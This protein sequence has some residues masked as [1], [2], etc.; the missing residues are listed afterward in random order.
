MWFCVALGIQL[1][2]YCLIVLVAFWV[3]DWFCVNRCKLSGFFI[4]LLREL[5]NNFYED[6]VALVFV[7]RGLI[8]YYVALIACTNFVTL[9]LRSIAYDCCG[10]VTAC[11]HLVA[12]CDNWLLL[13]VLTCYMVVGTPAAIGLYRYFLH[14]IAICVATT[15][16]LRV[17][18]MSEWC[19][20]VAFD[21]SLYRLFYSAGLVG[22]DVFTIRAYICNAPNWEV[23]ILN[24]ILFG[25]VDFEF[26]PLWIG[27]WVEAFSCLWLWFVDACFYIFVNL[28]LCCIN[29]FYFEFVFGGMFG[30]WYF[31]GV[32]CFGVVLLAAVTSF[33]F[34]KLLCV[35]SQGFTSLW[36]LRIKFVSLTGEH[37]FTQ[38]RFVVILVTLCVSRYHLDFCLL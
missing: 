18:F 32:F 19:L 2:G 1:S 33:E 29:T 21:F 30:L 27:C 11:A 7:F 28:Y 36:G 38:L 5:S 20:V 9:N 31:A 22:F 23:D 3:M 12:Y 24:L 14:D 35:V 16:F 4:L 10:N 13:Y 25:V 8:L 26:L 17:F 6:F 15:T 34:E 37:C